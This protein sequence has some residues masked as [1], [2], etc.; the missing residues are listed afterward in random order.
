LRRVIPWLENWEGATITSNHLWYNLFAYGTGCPDNVPDAALFE[1]GD[2]NIL[3]V[4]SIVSHTGTC[5]C[6]PTVD[7]TSLP[8]KPLNLKNLSGFECEAYL[9][10]FEPQTFTKAFCLNNCIP[11]G[12]ARTIWHIQIGFGLSFTWRLVGSDSP[13]T[14]YY[15]YSSRTWCYEIDYACHIGCCEGGPVHIGYGE[16]ES[17]ASFI[18]KIGSW[19]SLPLQLGEP[20]PWLNSNYELIVIQPKTRLILYEGT[21]EIHGT[22]NMKV[23]FSDITIK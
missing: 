1:F 13:S 17:F 6:R 16:E 12:I 5:R 18:S 21:T 23:Y 8:E 15:G 11:T 10:E 4:E 3:K 20:V 9:A 7:L 14:T 2:E 22:T 19:V